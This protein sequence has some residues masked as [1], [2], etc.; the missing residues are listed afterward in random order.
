[1]KSLKEILLRYQQS[2]A[3]NSKKRKCWISSRQIGKSFTIAYLL[4]YKALSSK[5]GLSLCISVN[6]RSASEIIM[7][8]KQFAE[9][10][11]LM[12][13]GRI[14]YDSSYDSIKF[15]TGSRVMS[16]P[17][18]TDGSNLRGWT[19]NC[20]CIDEAAFVPHLDSIMQGIAP[21]LT[22]DPNSELILTT[23]PAG[24]NGYFYSMYSDALNS[25]EWYVQNTTIQD[26]IAD[27]LKVDLDSL[28]SLCPDPDVFAQEYECKFLD[29]YGSMIDTNLIDWYDELPKGN[30]ST[31][32]GMDIGSRSDRSA[33]VQIKTNGRDS[34]VDNIVVLNKTS[35]EDQL[36]I[37]KEL[38]NK[39]HFHS[40]Y[41]DQNGIGSA[42]S[43]FITKQV[44]SRLKGFTFTGTNKTPMYEALRGG[45]FDHSIKFN[46][47][48]KDMI[49]SDFNNVQRIV[50]EDGKVK[51][52][53][54]HN[55]NGHSDI[56]SGLVLALQS[57]K[58][59]PIGTNRLITYTRPS[60]F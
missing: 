47:K 55:E 45:I 15:S 42:I 57:L 53:A 44:S 51:Y 4:C 5:N 14:D 6:A 29:E 11:K 39:E 19:A 37:V 16:L 38:N 41:I 7:K 35:Y 31:I 40:G 17:G 27:G 49:V 60:V 1:M 2:F 23:T 46:L 48:Y 28:K 18:S 52:Q 43:E 3:T 30:Y 58:D 54:G 32:M 22:R 8:C 21:T 24:K 36:R 12:S 50:T 13:K 20:I 56:T 33:I 26:A 25:D 59:N 9:A 34:Y 10:I